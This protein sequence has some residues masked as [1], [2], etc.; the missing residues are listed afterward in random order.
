[1]E[2]L[3][4]YLPLLIIV[5]S[6][7][8]TIIGRKKKTDRSTHE[9]ALPWETAEDNADEW[10]P[11]R[12]LAGSFQNLVEE[13]PKKQVNQKPI[14]NKDFRISSLS[15]T[16]VIVEPEEEGNLTFSFE[17]EDIKRAIIYSEIINRKEY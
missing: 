9:T 13:K 11:P 1:M 15:P 10:Q 7:I 14:I 2:K 5:V 4:E 12:R 17:E 16:Q 3:S 6:I 8:F